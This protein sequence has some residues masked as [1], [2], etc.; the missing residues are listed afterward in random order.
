ML[1][2]IGWS[3]GLAYVVLQAFHIRRVFAEFMLSLLIRIVG[4]TVIGVAIA[5]LVWWVFTLCDQPVDKQS[6]RASTQR[7][8]ISFFASAWVLGVANWVALL[9]P[10][11][12]ADCF[13]PHG[14]PFTYFH[15]GGMAGGGGFVWSG[16]A[17]EV[18]LV[19]AMG[20]LIG[21]I[22]K[23]VVRSAGN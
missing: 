14:I 1:E 5:A 15:E 6:I 18:F 23:V 20:T 11:S 16:V 2:G 17:A 8:A 9:R 22:W 3:V 12:C 13:A 4:E 19:V 21:W 10:I 7:Y